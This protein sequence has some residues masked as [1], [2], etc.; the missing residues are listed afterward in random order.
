MARQ[1]SEEFEI[2]WQS[3]EERWEFEDGKGKKDSKGKLSKK[4]EL[5]RK[6]KGYAESGVFKA[7]TERCRGS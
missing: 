2:R 3:F 6:D 5:S 4:L 1:L 7:R